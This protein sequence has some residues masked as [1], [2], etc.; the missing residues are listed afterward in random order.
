M[1]NYIL[2]SSK[3]IPSQNLQELFSSVHWE[4]ASDPQRLHQAML[5]SSTIVTAWHQNRLVGLVRSMDD[6]VWSANIDCLVVHSE[7]QHQGIGSLILR[8]L[9]NN[10]KNIRYINVSPDHISAVPFYKKAGFSETSGT[11]LQII[12]HL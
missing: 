2:K 9:L 5:K 6:G 7:Y 8:E 1:E 12:N 10:L 3:N 11:L 4:S